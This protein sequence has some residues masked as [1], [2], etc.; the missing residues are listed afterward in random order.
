MAVS[1]NFISHNREADLFTITELGTAFSR[2]ED[3]SSEDQTI[4]KK[5]I[6]AYPPAT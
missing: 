6:L 3:D 5:T 2:S 4:L 1:W